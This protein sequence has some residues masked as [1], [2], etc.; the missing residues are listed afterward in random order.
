MLLD[1]VRDS[2][3]SNTKSVVQKLIPTLIEVTI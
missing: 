3:G 1:N 2:I